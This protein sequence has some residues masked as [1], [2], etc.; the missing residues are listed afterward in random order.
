[1]TGQGRDGMDRWMR[2]GV[3]PDGSGYFV[4]LRLGFVLMLHY[5]I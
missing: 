2:A 4:L 1:M 3:T 5:I